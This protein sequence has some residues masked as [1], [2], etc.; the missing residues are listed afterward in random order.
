LAG[1]TRETAENFIVRATSIQVNEMVASLSGCT[2][3]EHISRAIEAF[4][5]KNLPINISARAGYFFYASREISAFRRI[6]FGGLHIHI[7]VVCMYARVIKHFRYGEE[8]ER[9][10][11]REREKE[12]ERERERERGMEGKRTRNLSSLAKCLMRLLS[13]QATTK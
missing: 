2:S 6:I 5:I 3:R 8:K 7:H 11:E 9:E 12:R 1:G 13:K 4:F 10:R